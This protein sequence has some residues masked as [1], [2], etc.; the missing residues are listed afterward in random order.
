MAEIAP[1]C[2]CRIM[3]VAIVCEIEEC[4]YV[5]WHFA[6]DKPERKARLALGENQQ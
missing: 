5:S 4:G 6:T 3:S 1:P 2:P